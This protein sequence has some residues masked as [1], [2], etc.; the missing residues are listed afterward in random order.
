[1]RSAE[2]LEFGGEGVR[3]PVG[4]GGGTAAAGRGGGWVR[5]EGAGEVGERGAGA[6]GIVKSGGR[7][8]V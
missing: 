2:V 3:R 7:R 6:K 1:M 5:F 4:G 8:A